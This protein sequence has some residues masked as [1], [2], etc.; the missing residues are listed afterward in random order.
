MARPTHKR[1][2]IAKAPF[3]LQAPFIKDV[4]EEKVRILVKKVNKCFT[5]SKKEAKADRKNKT[6][7]IFSKYGNIHQRRP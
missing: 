6:M 7:E 1:L 2:S 4:P 5:A 3:Q